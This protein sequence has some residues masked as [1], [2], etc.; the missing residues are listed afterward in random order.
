[1]D[2]QAL[3]EQL[4]ALRDR[5]YL[6]TGT[7]GPMPLA[8]A[9]AGEAL[10]RLILEEG[11]ASPPAIEAYVKALDGARAAFAR[12]IGAE[13]STIALM[14]STSE[15]IG[16]VAAGIDW[17]PGD[18]VVFSDLEHI[19]GI[20]PWVELSRRIGVK[21]V[22]LRSEGGY[23]SAD[24][25]EHALGERTR[26]VCLSH[27]SYSSGA[28]LPVKEVSALAHERGA[29]VVVDGAQGAGNV[30]V[31]VEDIGCDFYAVPGQKWL[32]GPEGTGALYVNKRALEVLKPTRVGWASVAQEEPL[33]AEARLHVD[34][35]RFETGTVHAPAF[36]ALAASIGVLESVGWDRIAARNRALAS[37][38]R[39][40][41]ASIEGARALTPEDR[42][43][44]LLTFAIEGVDPDRAVKFLWERRIVIRSIP[45][46]GALRASFH[47]FNNEEDVERLVEGVQ[48]CVAELR[49]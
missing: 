35:R 10:S 41:L 21:I 9:R 36:A 26:L 27:V 42:A 49:T 15:G 39:R 20:A 7:S 19:S 40:R 38:A 46:R 6:N 13:A 4:P 47:A 14:H 1:M 32:L 18:E 16:T 31:D 30:P 25:F 44:G 17:R 33:K 28:E 2:F 45:R 8:A 22:N 34:A 24:Q 3:R 23:L 43:T 11:F 5:V 12:A 48:A 29:L 37:L